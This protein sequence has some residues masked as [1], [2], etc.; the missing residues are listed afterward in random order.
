MDALIQQIK[1]E[2]N[3]CKYYPKGENG[4]PPYPLS[5]MLRVH[6]LQ[7]LYN[8]N[9][10]AMEDALYGI[11][12]TRR[13]TGLHLFDRL[14]D[15]STIRCF[16]LLLEPYKLSQVIFDTVNTQLKQQDL[17]TREA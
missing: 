9:D 10:P 13:F 7:L 4:N 8:L 16:R 15:E 3:L 11:E 6:C 2:N 17:L 5:V 12:S 14:P 1:L